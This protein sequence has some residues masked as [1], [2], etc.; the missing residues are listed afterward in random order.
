MPDLDMNNLELETKKSRVIQI[1]DVEGL[2]QSS[3]N[4][5]RVPSLREA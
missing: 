5:D 3:E 2:D 1:D 4:R